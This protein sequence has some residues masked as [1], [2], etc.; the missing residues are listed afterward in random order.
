MTFYP[1]LCVDEKS[2]F[3]RDARTHRARDVVVKLPK[4]ALEQYLELERQMV[5]TM[6]DKTID[7]VNAAVSPTNSSRLHRVRSMKQTKRG[8]SASCEA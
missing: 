4:E 1:P 8:G 6:D 7:A 3:Y 5:A 2:G